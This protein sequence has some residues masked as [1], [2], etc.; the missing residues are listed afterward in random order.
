MIANA[1]KKYGPAAR[2]RLDTFL[3]LVS[4][5]AHQKMAEADK[6]KLVND[7]FRQIPNLED[8][9]HWKL[10]DYWATPV[11][12]VASNGGDSEDFAI[13]KYFTLLALGVDMNKMSIVYVNDSKKNPIMV[14]AYYAKAE[15]TMPVILD[16]SLIHI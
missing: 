4:N 12:T 11:E 8:I 9:N 14:L 15:D 1:E 7:F 5:P 13:G 3:A 6:L 2:Q 10:E 16:L